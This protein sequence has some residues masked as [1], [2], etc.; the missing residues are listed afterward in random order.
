MSPNIQ[1]MCM[2]LYHFCFVF[3][4]LGKNFLFH[5]KGLNGPLLSYDISMQG[6]AIMFYRHKTV[7]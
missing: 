7:K 3:E 4:A 2:P 5:P 6:T 1:T